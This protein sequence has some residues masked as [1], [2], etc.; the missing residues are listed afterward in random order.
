MMITQIENPTNASIV[1]STEEGKIII[2]PWFTDGIYDGTWHNFPRVTDSYKQRILDS[3]DVCLITHLH[4]DHFYINTLKVLSKETKFVFPKTFG[5]QVIKSNLES[6]GF[7][8]TILLD[9]LEDSISEAGFTIKAIPPLNTSGLDSQAEENTLSIDG[10]FTLESNFCE[11]KLVFLADNNLYDERAVEENLEL[12]KEP[13]L[14]AFAYNG[15]L[16]TSLL[17]IIF[18]IKRKLIFVIKMKKSDLASKLEI[19]NR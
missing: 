16:W 14:I 5:W 1:V 17:I 15:L 19:L 13:D 6:N 8:N 9:F 3:V 7:K 11:L 4:K 12:L 2:D 18:H 10:G